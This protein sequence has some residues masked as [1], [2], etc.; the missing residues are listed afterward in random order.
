MELRNALSKFQAD[1]L[2][3]KKIHVVSGQ[4]DGASPPPAA[5][6]DTVYVC[7]TAGGSYQLN[8]LYISDGTSWV[9]LPLTHGQK[10]V[11][12]S[13]LVG[14]IIEFDEDTLYVWY[15]NEN[16]WQRVPEI[17]FDDILID[18]VTSQIIV[19]DVTGNIMVEA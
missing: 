13:D 14:G 4:I 7:T 9:E 11:S 3:E 12:S 8:Y 18:D 15:S 5:A 17:S 10:M 6:V 19:D 2:Y 1:K 16:L